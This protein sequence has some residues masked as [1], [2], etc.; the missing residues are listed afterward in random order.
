VRVEACCQALLEQILPA[1]DREKTGIC[2]DVGVGTFAFYCKR[3]ARLGFETVAIAVQIK[4]RT[5]H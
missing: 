2:L 5:P 1:I 4:I 3:F